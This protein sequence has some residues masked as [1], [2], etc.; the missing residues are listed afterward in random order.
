MMEWFVLLPDVVKPAY[1]AAAIAMAA[2]II[3]LVGTVYTVWRANVGHEKRLTT[4]LQHDTE[5][6]RDQRLFELR[7]TRFLAAND[8]TIDIQR[9]LAERLEQ[10]SLIVA[11]HGTIQRSVTVVNGLLLVADAQTNDA[12]S[13]LLRHLEAFIFHTSKGSERMV[14]L[15][16]QLVERN[17][18]RVT[19]TTERQDAL[20]ALRLADTEGDAGKL[21]RVQEQIKTLDAVLRQVNQAIGAIVLE[22]N[23]LLV[24]QA[25][26]HFDFMQVYGRLARRLI[27][28]MRR[29][30]GVPDEDAYSEERIAAALPLSRA[31][32]MNRIDGRRAE[33]DA[34]AAQVASL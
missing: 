4:Q 3:A 12:A 31:E 1:V 8:A 17:T 27:T 32:F 11:A 24:E 10:P 16:E 9:A 13:D 7:Q 2:S 23:K 20:V 30:L 15:H 22:A 18:Q 5:T 29:E 26:T 21:V 34:L 33:N 19:W 28:S 6:K 25:P 14:S